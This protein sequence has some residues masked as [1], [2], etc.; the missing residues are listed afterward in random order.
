MT[1]QLDIFEGE[2][3]AAEGMKHAQ[4]RLAVQQYKDNV[5]L[6]ILRIPKGYEFQADLIRKVLGPPPSPGI[7]GSV[8]NACARKGLIE[9]TG[10]MEKSAGPERHVNLNRVWRRV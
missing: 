7:T 6:C 8:M 4:L 2:R 1:E 5:V 3:L 9:F 10:R